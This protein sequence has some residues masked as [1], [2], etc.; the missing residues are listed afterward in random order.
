MCTLNPTPGKRRKEGLQELHC[1][2][3]LR[4]RERERG[5]EREGA[6]ERGSERETGR[7]RER[8]LLGLAEDFVQA[9]ALFG[10]ARLNPTLYT[11][12]STHYTLHPTLYTLPYTLHIHTT[13]C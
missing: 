4:E 5:S 6:R 3:A 1:H 8:D 11:L 7:G 12:H 9:V 10:V 13:H 2:R